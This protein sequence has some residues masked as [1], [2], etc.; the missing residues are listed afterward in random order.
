LPV[1]IVEINALSTSYPACMYP[2]PY[3]TF[4]Y[5]GRAIVETC[6]PEEIAAIPTNFNI[7]PEG[8]SGSEAEI[9]YLE[10]SAHYKFSPRVIHFN[11]SESVS[12]IE[13]FKPANGGKHLIEYCVPAFLIIV[14]L[15]IIL[16]IILIFLYLQH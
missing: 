11:T 8:Y 9:A 4:S 13:Y 1:G 6:T 15:A 14:I 12:F 10:Y 16:Y 5:L 3:D 7:F 2:Y